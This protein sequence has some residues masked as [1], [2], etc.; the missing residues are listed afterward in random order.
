[1]DLWLLPA[2]SAPERLAFSRD[3]KHSGTTPS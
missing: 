1:M 2:K 3:A